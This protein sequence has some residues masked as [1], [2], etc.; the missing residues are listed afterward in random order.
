MPFYGSRFLGDPH[1]ELFLWHYVENKFL[2]TLSNMFTSLSL[3]DMETFY[4][5]FRSSLLN[6]IEIKSER[7]GFEPKITASL[8]N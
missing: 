1:R 3:T 4:E 7:F 6:T 5:I 8:Q 2:T